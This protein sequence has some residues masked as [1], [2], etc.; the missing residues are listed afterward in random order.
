M[1][2]ACPRTPNKQGHTTKLNL[3][4][5]TQVSVLIEIRNSKTL[6]SISQSIARLSMLVLMEKKRKFLPLVCMC[7]TGAGRGSLER[8]C[9]RVREG[10]RRHMGDGLGA[11]DSTET[12]LRRS[13]ST[14]LQSDSV[15][16]GVT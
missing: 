5:E 2:Q 8:S 3:I 4:T 12:V 9:V 13:H 11:E 1:Y 6:Y 15:C 7:Q 10:K 16:L 14:I